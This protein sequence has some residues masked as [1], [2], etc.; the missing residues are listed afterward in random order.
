[1]EVAAQRPVK[2]VKPSS[3]AELQPAGC[4][5]CQNTHKSAHTAA[6]GQHGCTVKGGAH[7]CKEAAACR[8]PKPPVAE[9]SLCNPLL[10]LPTGQPVRVLGGGGDT[11]AQGRGRASSAAAAADHGHQQ[12]SSGKCGR[13]AAAAILC[14]QEC[15]CAHACAHVCVC[16]IAAVRVM[17]SASRCPCSHLLHVRVERAAEQTAPLGGHERTLKRPHHS[18]PLGQRSTHLTQ[19]PSH[20]R[21]HVHALRLQVQELE[22][23]R[24]AAEAKSRIVLESHHIRM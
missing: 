22:Q 17:M 4:G 11:R 9:A 3:T 12:R 5:G 19:P 21:L 18:C 24:A 10:P 7:A 13:A 20:T 2:P 6:V 15:V 14:V 8:V 16:V 23:I 1:M